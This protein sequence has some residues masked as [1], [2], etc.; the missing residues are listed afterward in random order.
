MYHGFLVGVYRDAVCYFFFLT[1]AWELSQ[2]PPVPSHRACHLQVNI[3]SLH[4][5]CPDERRLPFYFPGIKKTQQNPRL[6]SLPL[7]AGIVYTFLVA[8]AILAVGGVGTVALA[9]LSGWP[10]L[11]GYRTSEAAFVALFFFRYWRLAVNL[12]AYLLYRP[13][14]PSPNPRYRP[15]DCTVIVPTV[16]PG[17]AIFRQCIAS[18]A[19]SGPAGILV[20][21]IHEL[22]AL[23]ETT[24]GPVRL[25]FPDV[26]LQIYAHGEPNKRGQ[27][28]HVVEQI[29]TPVTILADSTV[30]FIPI[31][32]INPFRVP[33]NITYA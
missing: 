20:V 9:F 22:K 8:T 24:L 7:M 30:S 1:A 16:D 13:R 32:G 14:L 15:V 19:A 28:A 11:G 4:T 27:I 2:S 21:T 25:E 18:I 33:P 17:T 29:K 10:T 31:L 5:Y 3:A 6:P 26:D 12:V 23:A